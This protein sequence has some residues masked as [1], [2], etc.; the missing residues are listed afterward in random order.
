MQSVYAMFTCFLFCV[1]VEVLELKRSTPWIM[2]ERG[3]RQE[4]RRTVYAE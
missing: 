2:R 4:G 3:I 1:F